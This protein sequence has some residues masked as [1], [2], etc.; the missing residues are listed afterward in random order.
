MLFSILLC[1]AAPAAAPAAIAPQAK[2]QTIKAA[3]PATLAQAERLLDS[4]DYQKS[5]EAMTEA[6]IA[7]QRARIRTDLRDKA[8]ENVPDE[9]IEEVGTI[10]EEALR[11]TVAAN[12]PQLRKA[13]SL[14]YARYF[15]AAELS[16]IADFNNDPVMKKFNSVLPTLANEMMTLSHGIFQQALPEMARKIEAA[17]TAHKPPGA[18]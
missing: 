17:V 5:L 14:I 11:S 15:T 8:G 13:T 9:L 10:I 16:R 3:D 12:G 2:V 1:A 7:G 18:S 4:L 6:L